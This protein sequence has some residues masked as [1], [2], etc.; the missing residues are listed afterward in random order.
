MVLK[1][2]PIPKKLTKA[3]SST[4]SDGSDYQSLGETGPYTTTEDSDRPPNS[5]P[6]SDSDGGE[7][8]GTAT[9]LEDDTIFDSPILRQ[10][11]GFTRSNAMSFSSLGSQ[12]QSKSIADLTDSKGSSSTSAVSNP[13]AK[14]PKSRPSKALVRTE[15][16]PPGSARA[17][18]QRRSPVSESQSKL[19]TSPCTSPAPA[20]TYRRFTPPT[21]PKNPDAFSQPTYL[22]KSPKPQAPPLPRPISEPQDPK[23]VPPPESTLSDADVGAFLERPLAT[24]L[25]ACTGRLQGYNKEA[26]SATDARVWAK[27]DREQAAIIEN[28]GPA[29]RTPEGGKTGQFKLVLEPFE[30]RRSH[31][32]ARK[33][34]SRRVIQIRVPKALLEDSA[35]SDKIAAYL[36]Q[37]IVLLGRTYIPFHGPQEWCGDQHRLS[38]V[39]FMEWHNPMA[40]NMKQ[41]ISK[42]VTRY[43]ALGLSNVVLFE[44]ENIIFIDDIYSEDWPKGK[45]GAPAEKTLMA[46]GCGFINLAALTII[47]RRMGYESAPTA[48]Q[49]RFDGSKVLWVR[50]PT[51]TSS[52]PRIW[53]RASQNKIK[54]PTLDR[55]HRIFELVGPSRA[56]S[57]IAL[58]TQSIL[59]MHFNGVPSETIIKLFN[60]GLRGR[61]KLGEGCED[62]WWGES[63]VGANGGGVWRAEEVEEVEE[64]EEEEP[65]T[66]TGRNPYSGTPLSIHELVLELIQAGFR[67]EESYTMQFKLKMIIETLVKTAVE[68]YR[69]PLLDSIAA[70]IIPDPSANENNPQGLLK[71]TEIYFRSSQPSMKIRDSELASRYHVITGE[72]VVGRYPMRLPSDLQRVVAVDIAEFARYTDV[73]IVSVRGKTSVLSGGDMDGDIVNVFRDP[74]I[75]RHFSHKPLTVSTKDWTEAFVKKVES[76]HSFCSRTASMSPADAMRVYEV[77]ILADLISPQKGLYSMF[78]DNAV[79]KIGYSHEDTLRLAY[80]F[81]ALL[82]A[83][84]TGLRLRPGVFEEDQKKYYG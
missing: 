32:F 7:S 21:R 41:A 51:D 82:D 64:E 33:R 65:L 3:H 74:D 27:L 47:T 30:N 39:E 76:V 6:D 20:S 10:D 18:N 80:I 37:R 36:A 11:S 45:P 72:F 49:G 23:P 42:F 29:A 25:E 81:N 73:I 38:F 58:S 69:I 59:N 46:D 34:S 8:T 77:H 16:T 9:D 1:A 56:S 43:H 57:N 84:K 4:S 71:E 48:L 54:N 19:P 70:W 17:E 75:V 35:I 68:K 31:G 22:I 66:Y 28:I 62:S 24:D 40:L 12:S 44:K 55:A 63:G 5:T 83:S 61:C 15:D 78:H 14:P 60:H 26:S 52:I 53:I 50:H 13:G 2:Q 79:A 67:P